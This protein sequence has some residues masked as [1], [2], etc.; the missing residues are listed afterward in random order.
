MSNAKLKGKAGVEIEKCPTG[1]RG[2]DE[3][4]LGGLPKGRPTL[5]AGSAG[6]G[7]TVL[8][9]EFLARGASEFHENGVYMAFE[10]TGEELVQNTASMGF[11]LQELCARNKILLD[12]VHLDKSEIEETGDYNLDGLFIRLQ[13]AIKTVHAKRV[14]LDT[15]E[16]LFGG[17]SEESILRA[18]LARL[19]RWLKSTGVTAIVT[20]ETGDGLLTRHGLEEYVADC[21]IILDHRVAEQTSIRRLRV[22]KYRGS[23][24]GTNEYPFLIG[25]TGISVLPITSLHLNHEASTERV[26]T[27]IPRL[28]T[29]LGG[30]GFYRGSCTLVSGGAGTG[31][32]SVAAHF[33]RAACQRGERA[34]YFASEQSPAEIIRN[35]KSIGIDLG[36][37]VKRGLLYFH[38]TRP[39][40]VG[41]EQ[42][43]VMLHD[44]IAEIKPAVVVID[45]ITNFGV[46]GN[47]SEVKS[48]LSRIIDMLKG[49][50][51]T[52]LFTSLTAAG[53]AAENSEVE[54]SSQIDSWLLLR[55][56]EVNGERNRGLYIL[57]SRGMAHSNQIRE[58][59]L[60]DHGVELVD[61][62]VGS[63]G[64][65]TGSARAAQ[66]AGE[67]AQVLAEKQDIARKRAEL[68][69]KR[70]EL[71]SRV[72]ALQAAFKAE[73]EQMARSIREMEDRERQ[74]AHRRIDMAHL[75]LADTAVGNGH[76]GRKTVRV[77]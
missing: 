60:T 47:L 61:V 18:E 37:W 46:M 62:Y 68:S 72:D 39:S 77:S 17:F 22:V 59:I 58:F 15:I 67:Q 69:R 7:K 9:M 38:A 4:T 74:V 34:L 35:M 12:H 55:N 49:K 57:K 25:N 24:H 65:L 14:V 71:K 56:L 1:I 33:A 64:V 6:C 36:P 21:V 10:E 20:G 28:D 32:S 48:M 50:Q 13:N 8:A 5:I 30:K 31:K 40:L 53:G 54:I 27:G 29:M 51:I 75:R 52:S 11:G 70:V 45:P 76:G 66:E 2:L 19:F 73:E 43:L 63:G 16:A 26:P 44:Q 41:L 23:L 3:I 42:H